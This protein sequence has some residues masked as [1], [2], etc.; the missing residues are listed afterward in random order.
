M[1]VLFVSSIQRA[2]LFAGRLIEGEDPVNQLASNNV[3]ASLVD[4]NQCR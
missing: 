1:V 2:G 4:D 3:S